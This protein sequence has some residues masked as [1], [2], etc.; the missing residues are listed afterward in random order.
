GSS[1]ELAVRRFE[2]EARATVSL[3]SPHTVD[4][5]DFGVTAEGTC[6]YVME[7]LDGVDLETLVK[8]HGPVPAER[9]IYLLRQACHS[10]AEAHG[11]ELVHRDIKPAN[12]W[13]CSERAGD[14]DHLKVLDFGLVTLQ[15][16]M[17]SSS[18][19]LTSDGMITGTPAYLAPEAITSEDLDGRADIYSLGCV[20]Y[21]LLTGRLVFEANTPMAML[22]AHAKEL[23]APPSTLAELPVSAELDALVLSCLAKNPEDRPSS[24]RELRRLLAAC[25]TE[26][27]WTQERAGQWWMTLRPRG[28]GSRDSPVAG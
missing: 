1:P 23:P 5:Y 24:A 2:R 11:R 9:A 19:R 8:E 6:F 16:K 18:T 20:A 27:R 25:E 3:K 17:G 13:L 15:P 14:F 26:Q 7:L 4:L 12:L 21:W 10:L 22:V 28:L